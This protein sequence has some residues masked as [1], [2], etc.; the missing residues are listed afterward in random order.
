MVWVLGTS[1]E[2]GGPAATTVSVRLVNSTERLLPTR[3]S[4]QLR[5][6]C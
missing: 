3:P 5:R 6:T 1:A 2:A 4:Y